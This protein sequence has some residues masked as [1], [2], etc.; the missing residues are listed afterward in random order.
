MPVP[1][2]AFRPFVLATI[3]VTILQGVVTYLLP[4]QS[5]LGKQSS[6]FFGLLS[7]QRG[8]WEDIGFNLIIPLAFLGSIYVDPKPKGELL[9]TLV[10]VLLVLFGIGSACMAV[11]GWSETHFLV[12]LSTLLLSVCMVIVGLSRFVFAFPEEAA[13]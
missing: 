3:G 5:D 13:P 2:R 6:H 7:F 9:R 4:P 1:L 10:S 8:S 11:S 12:V